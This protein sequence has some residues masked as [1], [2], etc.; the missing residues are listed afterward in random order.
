MLRSPMRW[1]RPGTANTLTT[2]SGR[3]KSM[4]L[5]LPR[6]PIRRARPTRPSTPPRREPPP[7][8]CPISFRT[9]PGILRRTPKRRGGPLVLE[10]RLVNDRPRAATDYARVTAAGSDARIAGWECKDAYWATRQ[11]LADPDI[12]PLFVVNPPSCPAAHG[13][14]ATADAVIRGY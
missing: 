11:H 9:P 2:E 14:H 1:S 10:H 6:C 3:A 13:C 4:P 8:S 7:P 5:W 12:K